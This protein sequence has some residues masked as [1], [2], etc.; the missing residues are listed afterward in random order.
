MLFHVDQTETQTRWEKMDAVRRQF[1]SLRNDGRITRDE[2]HSESEQ[3]L[4]HRQFVSLLRC[5]ELSTNVAAL[6][7]VTLEFDLDD[8]HSINW[9]EFVAGILERP[10]S[11]EIAAEGTSSIQKF[12]S[13]TRKK[14]EEKY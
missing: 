4:D 9:M 13:E 1:F 8:S 12:N 7:H 5:M 6:R 10:P 3:G 14:K 2:E 11:R